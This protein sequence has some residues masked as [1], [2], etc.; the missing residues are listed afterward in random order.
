VYDL[1]YF[2]ICSYILHTMYAGFDAPQTMMQFSSKL[3][4]K[5]TNIDLNKLHVD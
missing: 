3:S 1:Q 2:A 5:M 4:C